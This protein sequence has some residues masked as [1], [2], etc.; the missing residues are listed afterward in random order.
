MLTVSVTNLGNANP[1]VMILHPA[2]ARPSPSEPTSRRR[3]G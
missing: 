2:T 1:T 3:A